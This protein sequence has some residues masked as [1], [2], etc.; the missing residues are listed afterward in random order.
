MIRSVGFSDFTFWDWI[1]YGSL[2]IAAFAVA[3]EGGIRRSP[4][5]VARIHQTKI[6]AVLSFG[7]A[8]L[9]IVATVV[10][11]FKFDDKVSGDSETPNLNELEIQKSQLEQ[12][13]TQLESE[14]QSERRT[15]EQLVVGFLGGKTWQILSE[16]LNNLGLKIYE[17][18]PRSYPELRFE[19]RINPDREYIYL[20]S[21]SSDPENLVTLES[22]I[23][24]TDEC[25]NI[26]GAAR[27]Q[28]IARIQRKI[29]HTLTNLVY[30]ETRGDS[31]LLI[32]RQSTIDE[33][34][35]T[36]SL[37]ELIN[38]VSTADRLARNEVIEI[39][40]EVP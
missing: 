37:S 32:R 12:R 23:D 13:V 18:D 6:G 27:N 14:L 4:D 24:A 25:W 26:G 20:Y 39:C 31:W 15:R 30:S 3:I 11:L 21:M 1:A 5:L 2:A 34:S 16:L 38:H 10:V 8:L 40:D 22:R 33:N 19:K 35:R 29:D 28:K 36:S 17:V 7:P 9:V